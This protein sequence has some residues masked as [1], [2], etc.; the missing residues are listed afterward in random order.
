MY[1]KIQ[2]GRRLAAAVAFQAGLVDLD[3]KS[4]LSSLNKDYQKG[5]HYYADLRRRQRFIED[6]PGVTSYRRHL[7]PAPAPDNIGKAFH[8]RQDK[9]AGRKKGIDPLLSMKPEAVSLNYHKGSLQLPLGNLKSLKENF[10][11]LFFRQK[12]GAQDNYARRCSG[13]ITQDITEI[14]VSRNQNS[15]LFSSDSKYFFIL[16]GSFRNIADINDIIAFI[17]QLIEKG[18]GNICVQ[19]K[20]HHA[21]KVRGSSSSLASK[22]ANRRE[23]FISSSLMGGYSALISSGVIPKANPSNK[24]KIGVLVFRIQGFPCWILGSTVILSNKLLVILFTPP[25]FH[26]RINHII[27]FLRNQVVFNRTLIS[28]KVSSFIKRARPILT[29]SFL[30]SLVIF[31]IIGTSGK[32][33]SKRDR[34]TSEQIKKVK[35]KIEKEFIKGDRQR[36][37]GAISQAERHY[38]NVLEKRP[39]HYGARVGL[40][41]CLSK[42]GDLEKAREHLEKVKGKRRFKESE[43]SI[44]LSQDDLEAFD[45]NHAKKTRRLVSTFVEGAELLEVILSAEEKEVKI[46]SV[47]WVEKEEGRDVINKVIRD[48]IKRMGVL[49]SCISDIQRRYQLFGRYLNYYRQLKEEGNNLNEIAEGL[50]KRIL[51]DIIR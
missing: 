3:N 17:L 29:H 23:A 38:K 19:N 27:P 21:A 24:I 46:I 11:Y 34:K 10:E 20:F 43:R 50:S 45:R 4:G 39:Q 51:E 9:G 7:P 8:H 15:F 5:N 18:T 6:G 40:I 16:K 42:K 22:A 31:G 37:R 2:G 33:Y 26:L 44:P 13:R 30:L 41:Y 14:Q 35:D 47:C 28:T 32:G 12:I 25:N 1:E 48:K 49:P 36:E